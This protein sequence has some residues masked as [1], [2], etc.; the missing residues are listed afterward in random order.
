MKK[1]SKKLQPNKGLMFKANKV[2][3]QFADDYNLSHCSFSD[4]YKMLINGQ[5][6][7]HLYTGKLEYRVEGSN[8]TKYLPVGEKN[9]RG[10]LTTELNVAGKGLKTIGLIRIV[11]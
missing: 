2:I 5:N 6:V 4:G 7:I 11:R 8:E 1:E 3:R 9:L 10:L